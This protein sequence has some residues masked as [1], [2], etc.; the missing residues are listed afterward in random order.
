MSCSIVDCLIFTTLFL[1]GRQLLPLKS[2]STICATQ[3]QAGQVAKCLGQLLNASTCCICRVDGDT[4]LLVEDPVYVQWGYMG[5]LALP[6]CH[7]PP[8][9][10]EA[11]ARKTSHSSTGMHP[12]VAWYVVV[13]SHS[14]LHSTMAGTWPTNHL[15]IMHPRSDVG[16][17]VHIFTSSV[18]LDH[19]GGGQFLGCI[20]QMYANPFLF[21]R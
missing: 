3:L 16:G 8:S 18:Y 5:M 20:H 10:L 7:C 17:E 2:N 4:L 12:C 9:T 21:I 13:V 15:A 14:P 19:W 6:Q 1:S 11:E